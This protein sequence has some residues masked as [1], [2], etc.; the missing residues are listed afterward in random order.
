MPM[1]A[2]SS[3]SHTGEIST[4]VATT[5]EMMARIIPSLS[6]TDFFHMPETA[7]IIKTPTTTRMPPNAFCTTGRWAKLVST[8]AMTMIMTR[9]G[10]TPPAVAKIAPGIPFLLYPMNVAVL[11][12]ITP[13]VHCPMAK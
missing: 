12:K 4:K 7:L 11:T 8:A 3:T 10:N 13:G 1:T 6:T 5:K 2:P 9:E